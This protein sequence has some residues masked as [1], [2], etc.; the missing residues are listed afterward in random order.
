MTLIP[1]GN[2]NS[3]SLAGT[4]VFLLGHRDSMERIMIDCGDTHEYND[5]FLD[6]FT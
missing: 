4:N 5:T 6:N 1:G 2:P 3:T